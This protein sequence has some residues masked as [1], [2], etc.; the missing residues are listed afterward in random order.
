MLQ[1]P[2]QAL[3][4][5]SD[6]ALCGKKYVM[7]GDCCHLK[8]DRASR[9]NSKA[10]KYSIH[11]FH[12]QCQQKKPPKKHQNNVSNL[13]KVNNKDTRTVLSTSVVNEYC[14]IRANKCKLGL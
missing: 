3:C 10:I 13:F 12:I 5:L 14:C 2:N 1:Y 11:H 8:C 9:S 6:R 4:E 7:T